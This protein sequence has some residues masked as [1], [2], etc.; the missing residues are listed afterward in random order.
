MEVLRNWLHLASPQ[1]PKGGLPFNYDRRMEFLRRQREFDLNVVEQIPSWPTRAGSSLWHK[2]EPEVGR[3]KL[4]YVMTL[5]DAVLDYEVIDLERRGKQRFV[6]FYPD[7]LRAFGALFGTYSILSERVFHRNIL[8]RSILERRGRRKNMQMIVDTTREWW[9]D[10][11][12]ARLIL[13][14]HDR[15][16]AASRI[17]E[18]PKKLDLSTGAFWESELGQVVREFADLHLQKVHEPVSTSE[19]R[20]LLSIRGY[21]VISALARIGTLAGARKMGRSWELRR[22]HVLVA[23]LA[24]LYLQRRYLPEVINSELPKLLEGTALRPF[25]GS[26]LNLPFGERRL[27]PESDYFE[28]NSLWMEFPLE[29][30]IAEPQTQQVRQ[31]FTPPPTPPIRETP[32]TPLQP[33]TVYVAP[34]RNEQRRPLTETATRGPVRVESKFPTFNE[35][36]QAELV[37]M[38]I[39][40]IRALLTRM[41]NGPEDVDFNRHAPSHIVRAAMFILTADAHRVSTFS[42]SEDSYTLTAFR[43]ALERCRDYLVRNE[44]IKNLAQL[45]KAVEQAIA[46]DPQRYW[47]PTSVTQSR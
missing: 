5:Y 37:R 39:D 38:N 20:R 3:P 32:I 35:E 43:R 24:F 44:Q 16:K 15:T 17:Q 19:V 12:L 8:E 46:R 21:E 28:K 27:K 33:T 26:L 34:Q 41:P 10:H 11:P 9:G 2:I 13:D 25:L 42:P 30:A 4:A 45:I 22:E 23:G 31:R 18:S 47:N 14:P 29:P 7:T 36:E 40:A 6:Y 1:T